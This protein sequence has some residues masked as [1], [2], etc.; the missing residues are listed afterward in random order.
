MRIAVAI[1]VVSLL[2]P[3][4]YAHAHA[5]LDRAE[6]R[7]GST[8]SAAPRQVSLWFTQSIE[9]ASSA[10]EVR[11]SA[12]ARADA[13]RPRADPSHRSLHIPLKSLRPGTY[14]VHW[15]VLSADG[16]NSEGTFSFQVLGR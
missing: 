9:P 3:A 5:M 2:L 10:V 15:R 8:V 14:S 7:V 1:T 4:I 11:D 6:P 12:G 16:H 13:G